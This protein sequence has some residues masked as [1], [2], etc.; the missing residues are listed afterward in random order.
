MHH[1][2]VLYFGCLTEKGALRS[3]NHC[4]ILGP[5]MAVHGMLSS[6]RRIT[7]LQVQTS[8]PKCNTTKRGFTGGE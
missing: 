1:F 5:S 8:A 4:G 6:A 3:T 2:P 7:L